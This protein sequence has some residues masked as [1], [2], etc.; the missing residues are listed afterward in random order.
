MITETPSAIEYVAMD[1]QGLAIQA[2]LQQ[3]TMVM[4][5]NLLHSPL[6]ALP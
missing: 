5:Q 6:A 2:A 1:L 3:V 4:Y